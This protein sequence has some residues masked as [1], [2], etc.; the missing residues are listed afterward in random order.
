MESNQ[1][2]KH[3]CIGDRR[4]SHT[5]NLLEFDKKILIRKNPQTIKDNCSICGQSK[6]Q[7]FTK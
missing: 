7:L 1:I 4:P 3:Y 6:R 2:R 5:I